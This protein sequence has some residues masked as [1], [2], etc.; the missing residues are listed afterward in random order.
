[1]VKEKDYEDEIEEELDEEGL[2]AEDEISS[3]EEGFMRGYAD[4]DEVVTCDECGHA[5]TEKKV[6]RKINGEKH[7][8]CC[9]DCAEDYEDSSE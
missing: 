6:S 7:F 2:L 8:F 4:E 5:I 9:N 3:A 1:M